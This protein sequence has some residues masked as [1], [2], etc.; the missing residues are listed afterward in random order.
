MVYYMSIR[1]AVCDVT[2]SNH[3]QLYENILEVCY[4]ILASTSDLNFYLQRDRCPPA[5]QVAKASNFD[6]RIA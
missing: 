3:M 6:L 4:V 5:K 2:S 1:H